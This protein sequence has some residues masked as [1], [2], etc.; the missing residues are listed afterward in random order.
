M[1]DE[2]ILHPIHIGYFWVMVVMITMTQITHSVDCNKWMKW[3]YTQRDKP[4]NQ[5]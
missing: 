3:F 2:L 1:F 4:T 5:I